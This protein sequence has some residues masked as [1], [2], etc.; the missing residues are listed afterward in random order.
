MAG[1]S[2]PATKPEKAHQSGAEQIVAGVL[3]SFLRP[4]LIMSAFRMLQAIHRSYF[5]PQYTQFRSPSLFLRCFPR[6]PNYFLTTQAS[7]HTPSS[8]LPSFPRMRSSLL[9]LMSNPSRHARHST[10]LRSSSRSKIPLPQTPRGPWQRFQ[11]RINRIP[12][13]VL[14]WGGLVINGGVYL[15]WQYADVIYV[16]GLSL[17]ALVVYIS[18]TPC[19]RVWVTL[20]IIHGCKRIS[21]LV[22]KIYLKVECMC[23]FNMIWAS[24]SHLRYSAE[25]RY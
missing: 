15:A 6:G 18:F 13:K 4:P 21:F 1:W 3:G 24:Y 12:H 19:R 7:Q 17:P 8:M 14:F 20:H 22:Y 25:G 23:M 9:Q 16:R 2:S 5:R 10:I 11:A